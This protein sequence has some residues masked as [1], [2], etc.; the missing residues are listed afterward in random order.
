MKRFLLCALAALTV[1]DASAQTTPGVQKIK[2]S[3]LTIS[4]ANG[5]GVVDIEGNGG[6]GG[7][8]PFT[9][10]VS[11][12]NVTAKTG[13]DFR[14]NGFYY[15]TA[16]PTNLIRYTGQ[17]YTL[18][19]ATQYN[20]KP[21]SPNAY[22]FEGFNVLSGGEFFHIDNLYQTNI[23]D[24]WGSKGF[25]PDLGVD[26]YTGEIGY[27]GTTLFRDPR[28]LLRV[29]TGDYTVTPYD[30]EIICEPTANM[31]L[32]IP[33]LRT[34]ANAGFAHRGMQDYLEIF[35][36]NSR[37]LLTENIGSDHT[38]TVTIETGSLDPMNVSGNTA[39]S[40]VLSWGQGAR[41]TSDGT[42]LYCFITSNLF[43][44]VT[45]NFN[46]PVTVSSHI[47]QPT[48]I[49]SLY[50][51]QNN[52]N[53]V[54]SSP[55]GNE[56]EESVNADGIVQFFFT[57]EQNFAPE[58]FIIGN[59]AATT[60][61]KN[62][63]QM[64]FILD[65]GDANPAL[66]FPYNSLF[67]VDISGTM[68]FAGDG[69]YT[70]N[71]TVGGNIVVNGALTQAAVQSDGGQFG[72]DGAGNV[73]A[74][75]IA[76]NSFSSTSA[77]FVNS[78]TQFSVT[79]PLVT[80]SFIVRTNGTV[81]AGTPFPL[82]PSGPVPNNLD[83][84]N[85]GIAGFQPNTNL[86]NA[87]FFWPDGSFDH[88]A[89][90]GLGVVGS[91]LPY[92]MR[93]FGVESDVNQTVNFRAVVDL[94]NGVILQSDSHQGVFPDLTLRS[95]NHLLL[96]A[97][98][99]M[100]FLPVS[101]RIS[102]N[103][104]NG[105]AEMSY[106]N[107]NSDSGVDGIRADNGD[108][109]VGNNY[110]TEF[111]EGFDGDGVNGWAD[112]VVLEQVSGSGGGI[113]LN[114]YSTTAN[115]LLQIHRDT[116]F[117]LDSTGLSLTNNITVGNQGNF[118]GKVQVGSLRSP[119]DYLGVTGTNND[120]VGVTATNGAG[121]IAGNWWQLDQEG[122]TGHSVNN[123]HLATVL[124]AGGT[125][126]LVLNPDA[127]PFEVSIAHV[128]AFSVDTSLHAHFSNQVDVVGN[129][130]V[131][132][133]VLGTNGIGSYSTLVNTSR[134]V[135]A[136]G[137]TNQS[138]TVSQNFLVTAVSATIVMFDSQNNYWGGYTNYTGGLAI[139]LGPLCYWTNSG[140]V[141]FLGNHGQ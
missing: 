27:D 105:L 19:N 109:T 36:N 88:M 121:G 55:F 131:N 112:H 94:T 28:E 45:P 14:T 130:S 13:D 20:Y 37:V 82:V 92:H 38:K 50:T 78:A 133:Y 56:L 73:H 21:N 80:N 110:F 113:A 23:D 3:T 119:L 127:G 95:A 129:V 22:G 42:I 35:T 101:K 123:W 120:D 139:P 118:G 24:D 84:I 86:W 115:I 122:P 2:S 32:T 81:Q 111:Q 99:T 9:T 134:H 70:G 98:S 49:L 136:V 93:Y 17:A 51:T 52:F 89:Y 61:G 114:G 39:T 102:V 91:L 11:I 47:G 124:R 126:G 85:Y 44:G 100:A 31:T 5:I 90:T 125:G 34:D 71:V 128:G 68:R 40:A 12:T 87:G 135:T 15:I 140:T 7:G 96:K 30:G 83:P 8:P 57:N 137:G 16:S 33:H 76:V 59:D 106:T 25:D 103:S 18:Y 79:N 104:T 75:S 43:G 48:N 41:I 26:L 6:G 108:G 62:F 10:D 53:H 138:T 66:G 29:V 65:P 46:A 1:L 67:S 69:V 72:S 63:S 74:N 60:P 64:D 97:G 77:T 116:Q 117:W 132:G 141:A 58:A 4:P 107:F 54:L